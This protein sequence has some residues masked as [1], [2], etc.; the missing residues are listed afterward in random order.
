VPRRPVQR[1]PQ[2]LPLLLAHALRAQ[3]LP[4]G[5]VNATGRHQ[6]LAD[7]QVPAPGSPHEGSR[8]VL[9]DSGGRPACREAALQR[10]KVAAPRSHECRRQLCFALACTR[11]LRQVWHATRE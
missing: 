1:R 6:E 8:A 3:S 2:P 7:A 5:R 9:V 10:R 11:Q 4:T